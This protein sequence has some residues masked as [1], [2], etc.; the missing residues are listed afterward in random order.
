MTKKPVTQTKPQ[1]IDAC[2]KARINAARVAAP[3]N[4]RA[5]VCARFGVTPSIV[6]RWATQRGTY[7]LDGVEYKDQLIASFPPGAKSTWATSSTEKPAA[8][9]YASSDAPGIVTINNVRP[10]PA[11]PA[12]KAPEVVEAPVFVEAPSLSKAQKEERFFV[13]LLLFLAFIIQ[14]IHLGLLVRGSR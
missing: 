2:T 5:E 13:R 3:R 9:N 12:K 6:A 7:W 4:Q 1:P 14:G 10:P 8:W 11:E